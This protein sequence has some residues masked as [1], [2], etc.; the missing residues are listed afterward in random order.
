MPRAGRTSWTATVPPATLARVRELVA[1]QALNPRQIHAECNLARYVRL[2]TFRHWVTDERRRGTAREQGAGSREPGIG[3]SDAAPP[4][5]L[6]AALDNALEAVLA[7]RVKVYELVGVIRAVADLQRVDLQKAAEQ[8]AAELHEAKRAELR[9]AIDAASE[10]GR[11]AVEAQ[12]IY[13]AIDRVMR[14]DAA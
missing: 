6:Q 8:R 10:G 13:A 5:L 4:T 3:N 7:G 14:G 12:D 1:A 9:R 11:K 2:S